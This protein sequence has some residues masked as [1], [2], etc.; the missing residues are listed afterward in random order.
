MLFV[1]MVV[2]TFTSCGKEY[3]SAP[4]TYPVTGKI[5]ATRRALP[6]GGLVEFESVKHGAEFT[7]NGVIEA[8]G[9]FSLKIPY[10]DRVLS[11]ATAGPHTVRVLLPLEQ[12]GSG[13]GAVRI[14][15]EFEVKPE[16]NHFTINMPSP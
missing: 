1:P 8:D 13:S 12:Q 7:A 2:L 5:V 9:K 14:K 11:G 10:V 6:A 4:E 3:R 15:G 16:E